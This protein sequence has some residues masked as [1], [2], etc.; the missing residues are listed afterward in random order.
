MGL[1]GSGSSLE[2]SRRADPVD[3]A[4]VLPGP[5]RRRQ[6]IYRLLRHRDFRFF[7]FTVI[8]SGVA[9]FM[10]LLASGWLIWELSH[11]TAMLGIAAFAR[12]V[13][14]IALAL[15]IGSLSDRFDRRRLLTISQLVLIAG[16]ATVAAGVFG[17]WMT[18]W[19]AI[20]LTTLIGVSTQ[21]NV[22]V[23]QAAVGDLLPA[24]EF[25]TG[26]FLYQV[27]AN[28]ARALGPLVSGAV[29]AAGG[30]GIAF[31]LQGGLW[32]IVFGLAPI[33]FT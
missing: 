4:P 21:G 33:P 31:A 18:V 12:T 11:S 3:A 32:V 13:P 5:P 23:R 2:T 27:G 28:G 16:M 7:W 15:F 19:L 29:I 25:M 6:P 30:T 8:L 20:I 17:G 22:M 1:A 9:S 24:E 26:M 14:G 10:E